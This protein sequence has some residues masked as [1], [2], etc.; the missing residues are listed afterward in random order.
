MSNEK[1]EKEKLEKKELEIAQLEEVIYSLKKRIDDSGEDGLTKSAFLA[2][3]SHEIRTPMNGVMGM[4]ELLLNTPVNDRQQ[5]L[6]KTAHDSAVSL[7]SVI[8]N[9][10]DHSKI[11]SGRIKLRKEPFNLQKLLDDIVNK[12]AESAQKKG[13]EL[14]TLIPTNIEHE[15]IGDPA[16]LY[17]IIENLLDN[18]IKFTET[19]VIEL[20]TNTEI[21]NDHMQI[22]VSVS[23]TG[24]RH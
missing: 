4:L 1:L 5:Y 10:F 12:V 19:G 20:I 13:I 14:I 9:I 3:I 21:I 15:V 6:A 18:A 16:R 8:N 22:N 7:L 17:Q 2:T 11:E 23:D 24:K